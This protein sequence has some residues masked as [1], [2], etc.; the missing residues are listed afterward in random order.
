MK[1]SQAESRRPSSRVAAAPVACETLERRALLSG[2]AVDA[3]DT[4]ATTDATVDAAA[5]VKTDNGVG[6]DDVHFDNG[7]GKFHN[8]G[9]F[10]WV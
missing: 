8:H 9:K 5:A 7:N 6:N 1:A 3:I 10:H 4:T 2:T